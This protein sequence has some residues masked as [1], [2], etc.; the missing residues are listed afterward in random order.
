MID[1]KALLQVPFQSA[2]DPG[3]KGELVFDVSAWN[4]WIVDG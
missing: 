3:I 2:S 4:D 1:G